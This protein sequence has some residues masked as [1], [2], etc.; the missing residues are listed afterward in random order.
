MNSVQQI[1]RLTA[2]PEPVKETEKGHVTTF[3]IAVSRPKGSA[4]AADFFTVEAWGALADT[5]G[6]Y[7]REG[8]EVGVQGRL[9]QREWRTLD[10]Q[11]RERV[12]IV[13][14]TVDFLRGRREAE[15]V[16]ATSADE[17]IAF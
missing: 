16:P 1:G 9:E 13:A 11:T 2:D 8:R 3:R 7:L 14:R 5:C 10:D 12:V 15:P 17:A 4:K 6:Q